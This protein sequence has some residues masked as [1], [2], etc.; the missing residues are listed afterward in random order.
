MGLTGGAELGRSWLV[1]IRAL[2]IT[3]NQIGIVACCRNIFQICSNVLQYPLV[4]S[5][6]GNCRWFGQLIRLY[7]IWFGLMWMNWKGK[8]TCKR[9]GSNRWSN[10]LKPFHIFSIQVNSKA[11]PS[12]KRWLRLFFARIDDDMRASSSLVIPVLR[13]D[14]I[15]R[16]VPDSTFF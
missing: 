16:F 12:K 13:L 5:Y 3:C 14:S 15:H 9:R 2:V 1:I 7:L 8:N 11:S 6:C 4:L 10:V